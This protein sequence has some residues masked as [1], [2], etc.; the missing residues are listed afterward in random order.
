[1]QRDLKAKNGPV[2]VPLSFRV[3]HAVQQRLA[4]E[5][6]ASGRSIAQEAELRL[7][8]ALCDERSFNENLTHVF[9]DNGSA[10]LQLI[11][12]LMRQSGDW[13]DDPTAYARIRRQVD[14]ILDAVKPPGEP[15][16]RILDAGV[17]AVTLLGQLFSVSP[18]AVFLRWS[19]E[20]RRL[21][22]P[23]APGRI[24]AWLASVRVPS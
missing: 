23:A 1:M 5:S 6:A 15:A 4:A 14:V 17:E 24:A 22:G 13:I 8:Q 19:I 7:E 18:N 9:G 11:G 12:F 16:P 10:V 3:S 21:L 20:L 2:R